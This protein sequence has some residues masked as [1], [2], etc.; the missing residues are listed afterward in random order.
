MIYG[1]VY[2]TTNLINGRVYIGQHKYNGW[3]KSYIGSGKIFEVALK[4][5]EEKTLSVN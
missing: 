1:Y 5:T 4:N 3:D 2:K